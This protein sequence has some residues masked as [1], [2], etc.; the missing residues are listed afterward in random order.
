MPQRPGRPRLRS[1]N[2][3]V[4]SPTIPI[5]G[6]TGAL[7]TGLAFRWSSGG[8]KVV[9]GSRDADRAADLL[10]AFCRGLEGE[11]DWAP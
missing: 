1:V 9:L 10:A 4:E 5:V 8:A 2:E 6:G 3:S 7:G 11:I